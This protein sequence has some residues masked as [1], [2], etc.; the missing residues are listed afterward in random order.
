MKAHPHSGS[1]ILWVLVAV[2]LLASISYVMMENSRTSTGIVSGEQVKVTANRLIDYANAARTEYQRA[3][4]TN[5][6]T[7][8]YCQQIFDTHGGSLQRLPANV[9]GKSMGGNAD[10]GF[11]MDHGVGADPLISKAISP[12][13]FE[14]KMFLLIGIDNAEL[15]GKINQILFKQDLAN[16]PPVTVLEEPAAHAQFEITCGA[17]AGADCSQRRAACGSYVE[18]AAGAVMNFPYVFYAS[19]N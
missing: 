9:R 7:S 13:A 8:R 17:N 11:W 16:G 15:C 3:N 10:Y 6:C 4:L 19:L 1:V 14:G 18:I 2:A 5:R 12:P